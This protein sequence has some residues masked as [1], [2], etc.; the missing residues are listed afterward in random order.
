MDTGKRQ[1]LQDIY[2][3]DL[4]EKDDYTPQVS[5]EILEERRRDM[6]RQRIISVFMGLMILAL[7]M[8]LIFLIVR[9]YINLQNTNSVS[10]AVVQEY[11][12]RHSLPSGEQW[13]M[14]FPK[15]FGDS[16]WNGEGERPFNA[17]WVKRAAFNLIL[18][19]QATRFK[20]YPEAILYYET[21]LQILPD[22]EGVKVPLGTLYFKTRKFDKAISLLKDVPEEDLTPDVLNNLG[23]AFMEAK[24]YD[25]AKHYLEKAIND[26]PNYA[27]PQKNLAMLYRDQ[28]KADEAVMAYER[29]IDLRPN[30]L[31]VRQ[32]YA[33]YLTK[34]GRWEQ[35]A[36]ILTKLTQ[37]V[38]DVPVLFFLLARVEN[39][40]NHPEKAL[41]AI[42][43]GVE[44]S[45]PR[46]AL[47]YMGDKEFDQLRTSNQFQ[48]MIQS[49][50]EA[51]KE[52]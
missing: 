2:A 11:I 12:P 20:K 3:T 46:A 45:D 23:A 16:T 49:L 1:H 24:S 52:K 38:K 15:A 34:L 19:E 22:L 47:A 10:T 33:L 4:G 14:D 43:R 50:Q 30:D 44:L 35:A 31:D 41:A 13:V 48:E 21:A 7:S 18:A 17:E 42:R 29:Y 36:D 25:E 8:S 40:N 39:H 27:E 6:Q 28:D 51:K 32:A 5:S 9:E 26:R 37:D